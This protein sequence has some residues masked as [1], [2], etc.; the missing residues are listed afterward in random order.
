MKR[1][2][3]RFEVEPGD[4]SADRYFLSVGARLT[5]LLTFFTKPR[6]SRH[7]E[8]LTVGMLA[9]AAR[10]GRWESK[11]SRGYT[12]S[13]PGEAP[14]REGDLPGNKRSEGLQHE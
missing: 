3:L 11:T 10:Q 4:F 7:R 8:P 5:L 1:F 2:F 13:G 9:S 14:G 6:A 12:G